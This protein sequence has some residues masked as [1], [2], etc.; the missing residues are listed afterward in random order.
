MLKEPVHHRLSLS[1]LWCIAV[2]NPEHIRN[3]AG[4]VVIREDDTKSRGT[5][6]SSA[7]WW[8]WAFENR[9]SIRGA[10][11]CIVRVGFFYDPVYCS[12]EVRRLLAF[13]GQHELVNPL[14]SQSYRSIEAS[15]QRNPPTFPAMNN[16]EASGSTCAQRP[17]SKVCGGKLPALTNSILNA[18]WSINRDAISG[19]PTS[20]FSPLLL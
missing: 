20:S 7:A 12:S 1:Y 14:L 15:K 10:G 9:R 3:D 4:G 16:L 2:E 13:D 11:D 5:H 17:R 6:G 8:G 19:W 18:R